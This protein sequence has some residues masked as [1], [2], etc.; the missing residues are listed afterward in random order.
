M[1]FR[2][3]ILLPLS[4]GGQAIK[5]VSM[6]TQAEVRSVIP[7]LLKK[8]ETA[9]NLKPSRVKLIGSAG[10][11]PSDSD[12]SGDLDV[13]VECESSLVEQ[14]LEELAGGRSSR[15]MRGIG[16]YSFVYP[17]G[18]KLVQV[19][20][21]P[22]ENIRFAQWSFQ[23]SE[24]DL[25]QGLKGAQRNELFFAVAK[26]MPQEVLETEAGEPVKVRRY[27]YDLSRGLMTG[28]RTRR[29][30]HGKLVKNFSTV[31]KKV[32]S[33][34]PVTISQLMFGDHTP[35]QL[36]TFD[37]TLRAIKSA[38]FIHRDH[39]PEILELALKGIKNKSLKI[40]G[41]IQKITY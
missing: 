26:Y 33:S 15:A 14:K 19:D 18:N 27:F 23:A 25:A 16:V 24:A 8:I 13:A 17:V 10:K 6:I 40:P 5:G 36:S 35:T 38:S 21:M 20:L 28:V 31:E 39:L 29:N 41:S 37:G 11:K 9:L 4:E 32:I 3:F 7:D 34:D 12:L 22:V 1:R 30:K 2:E